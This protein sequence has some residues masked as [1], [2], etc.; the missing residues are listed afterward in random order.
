MQELE[1]KQL[2]T[3][4]DG[5]KVVFLE[6]FVDPDQ[7][8]LPF[9]V[10]KSD[11]AALYATTDL[12]AL[13]YRLQT[14]G[15][16]RVIYVVDARQKQHF[17][18]LFATARKAGWVDANTSLEH[19]PF[20]SILGADHKPFKTRSGES[21]KLSTLLDEAEQR[22]LVIVSNKQSDLDATT[23]QSIAHVI[24]IGAL[25]YADLSNDKVRDYVF[26]WETMLSFDGNTAPYLQNAYVRT[27]AL[28]RKGGITPTALHQDP[29]RISTNSEH[30]LV[31][32]LL[33]FAD[34]INSIAKDLALQRL[35]QYL[36]EVAAL[37]HRFYEECPILSADDEF[38]KNSRLLL[39]NSTARILKTG[40]E[41]LGIEVLDYM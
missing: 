23:Q 25:K 19:V 10:R 40:L 28:F 31:V 3:L 8:P 17:A 38:I 33:S 35:C 41:L 14:L 34:I 30:Q 1:Q 6:G 26:N 37:F 27:Q 11:G 29:P 9:I 4:S 12:A 22:A 7:N 32:K 21:V 39:C 16:K 2:I 24:G 18:M 15:A 5:A 36:Y 20:G 13:K